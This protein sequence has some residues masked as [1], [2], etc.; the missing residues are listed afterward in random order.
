M[1]GVPGR[2]DAGCRHRSRACAASIQSGGLNFEE[3]PDAERADLPAATQRP[4][5]ARWTFDD[6]I[7]STT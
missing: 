3:E 4:L 6:H 5:T 7:V 2:L 1:R